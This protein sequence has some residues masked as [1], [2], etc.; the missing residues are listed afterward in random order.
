MDPKTRQ[1][2]TQVMNLCIDINQ[3][4]DCSAVFE[5]A[6]KTLVLR[7]YANNYHII[8]ERLYSEI[9]IISGDDF[10]QSVFE[11][12]YNTFKT[13]ALRLIKEQNPVH[14]QHLKTIY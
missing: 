8:G 12:D 4:T 3:E 7:V 9:I 11:T 2:I 14:Y 6:S 5:L 1:L 13:L 10:E